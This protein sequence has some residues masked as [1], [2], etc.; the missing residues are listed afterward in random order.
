[1][2]I[3][4]ILASLPCTMQDV[5]RRVKRLRKKNAAYRSHEV[6]LAP[7]KYLIQRIPEIADVDV[8]DPDDLVDE[9]ARW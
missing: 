1:M 9:G 2:C 7:R 8:E 3:F 6:G 4:A 5:L